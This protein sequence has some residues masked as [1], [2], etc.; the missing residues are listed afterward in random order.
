MLI[1]VSGKDT[2]TG[3]TLTQGAGHLA[4][5]HDGPLLVG[6]HEIGE[7]FHHAILVGPRCRLRSGSVEKACSHIGKR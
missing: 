7:R 5:P 4:D 3:K 2:Y 6:D 1:D